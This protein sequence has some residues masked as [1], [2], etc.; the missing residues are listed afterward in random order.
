MRDSR[1]EAKDGGKTAAPRSGR[2][3]FE[4]ADIAVPVLVMHG[5]QDKFVPFAHGQWLAT[6]IPGAEA[7]L[8]D[9]EGHLTLAEH[10]QGAPSRSAHRCQGDG[11]AQR[12][13]LRERGAQ[14]HGPHHHPRQETQPAGSAGPGRKV[15]G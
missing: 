10:R 14:R 4:L 12:E 5:G 1:A 8:L 6:H 11:V 3:G 7:R 15:W 9:D 13:E 2:W